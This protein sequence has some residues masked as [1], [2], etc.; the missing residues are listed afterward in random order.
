M[1]RGGGHTHPRIDTSEGTDEP[2]V[3]CEMPY[4]KP[5]RTTNSKK[6]TGHRYK[7]RH[8]TQQ[9][10]RSVTEDNIIL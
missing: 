2:S 6:G 9:T 10:P 8:N 3:D 4:H 5:V 1:A 7:I